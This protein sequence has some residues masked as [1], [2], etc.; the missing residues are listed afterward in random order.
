MIKC[1]HVTC[2]A[3]PNKEADDLRAQLA[4]EREAAEAI[5][6]AIRAA[7][8]QIGE[9]YV[10]AVRR[11]AEERDE[12]EALAERWEDRYCH[13]T[14]RAETA[15]LCAESLRKVL[16]L[17]EAGKWT[18]HACVECLD[19]ADAKFIAECSPYRMVRGIEIDGF[20]CHFHQAVANLAALDACITLS[21]KA[22]E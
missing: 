13:Q 12:M 3:C 18:D 10:D 21:P 22:D 20:R 4:E 5:R 7:G 19:D 11:I 14:I 17:A 6:A 15:S 16:P 1:D 9:S 2:H 8:A